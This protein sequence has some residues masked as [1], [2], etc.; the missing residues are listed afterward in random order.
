[1]KKIKRKDDD[2]YLVLGIERSASPPEIY[3]AYRQLVD[4]YHPHYLL[5]FPSKEINEWMFEIMILKMAEINQAYSEIMKKEPLDPVERA[6]D[7]QAQSCFPVGK[8]DKNGNSVGECERPY[9]RKPEAI[10][11]A[12]VDKMR[13]KKGPMMNIK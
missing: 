13:N 3:E 2:P 1:M 10:L 4:R 12:M 8:I 11:N 6:I 9:R 7:E 5:D